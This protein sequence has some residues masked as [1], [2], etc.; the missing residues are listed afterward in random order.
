MNIIKYTSLALIA[1]S[2]LTACKKKTT[3][4]PAKPVA[5][6]ANVDLQFSNEVDGM[7]IEFGKMQYTNAAGNLYQIDLL[8]YYITNVKL[9]KA[10]SSFINLENYDLINAADPTTCVVNGLNIPNGTYTKIVFN[11]GIPQ[12]RNHTGAQDGDLEPAKGMIWDW[13]TG[14][15]FFKHEGKFKNSSN[16][17]KSLV[18]HFATDRAFTIVEM[19]LSTP[20]VVNGVDKKVFFKFNLNKL[21]TTPT[22]VDFNVDYDR[23]SSSNM[24]FPWLDNLKLSFYDAFVV[25]RIE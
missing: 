21:Y 25:D 2:T 19:P 12:D 15:V 3:E 1:V 20:M 5:P 4:E 23:Q 22:N 6:A 17:T 8:K 18:F 7:P 24:D 11:V 10:D 9:Y 14:Y 13:N 16:Q